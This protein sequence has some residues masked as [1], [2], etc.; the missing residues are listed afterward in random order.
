MSVVGDL[1]LLSLLWF[2]TCQ[3]AGFFVQ[4]F[5]EGINRI[6]VHTRAKMSIAGFTHI[7][8]ALK[9]LVAPIMLRMISL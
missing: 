5:S 7:L 9:I 6:D 8:H 3:N 2:G 1:E 4:F